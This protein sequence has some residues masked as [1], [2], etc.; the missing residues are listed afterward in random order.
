MSQYENTRQTL[1]RELR[2]ET[3]LR[4]QD[5][6]IVA[7]MS[8]WLTYDLPENLIRHYKRPVCIGQKQKWFLLR[9]KTTDNHI[10]LN[11]C[12]R[13]EFDSWKWVDFWQPLR[14]VIYFKQNVYRQ[15]LTEFAP[16][17]GYTAKDLDRA[18]KSHSD[19][20]SL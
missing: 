3:G 14:E 10:S 20:S 13:P 19:Q 7:E 9:L 2:E 1:F 6:E 12:E 17:L 8:R 5:I 16:Y 11:S 18:V 4:E 15:A